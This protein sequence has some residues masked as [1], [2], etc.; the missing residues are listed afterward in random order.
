M[1]ISKAAR[2]NEI[3]VVINIQ[4]EMNCAEPHAEDEYCP[5]EKNY[6]FNTNVVF[7]RN[8]AVIDR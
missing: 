5:E 1:A 6:L 3:Y 4:E 8:G 7:D 2:D